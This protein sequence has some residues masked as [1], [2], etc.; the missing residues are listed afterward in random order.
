MEQ[1]RTLFMSRL[2]INPLCWVGLIL[3]LCLPSVL[4]AQVNVTVV[5]TDVTCFGLSDGTATATATGGWEPYTFEWSNGATTSAVTGLAAGTYTVKAT[6]KDLGYDIDT[7][8][9]N[10]PLQLGV[11]VAATQPQI[12]TLAPDGKAVATPFGGVIP[13]TYLWNTGATTPEIT[14]LAAG[15][16]TVTVRDANGCT[17]SAS[18][19]VELFDEGLWISVMGTPPTCFDL[20]NGSASVMTM[21]GTAPYTYVWSNG[22]STTTITNLA[23]G[24][25]TVTVSDANGCSHATS[26]E[27]LGPTKVNANA[28]AT[29]ATCGLPG[30]ASVAPTGGTGPYT[31]SWN[32]GSTNFTITVQPGTYTVT[33]TDSKGCTATATTTVGGG[34]NPLTVNVTV[35]SNAGCTTSGSATAIASGGSGNYAYVWDNGQTTATATLTAGGHSVT[36]T[37]ITTGCTGVGTVT[38]TSVTN[39]TATATSVTNASCTTGGSATATGSGGTTPYTYA[40]DNGQTTQTATNLSAGPHSVTVTD[41]TGCIAI[42]TVTI[43]QSQG[44]TVTVTANTTASCSGVG[45]SATANASGGTP[46]YV[47]LWDNTQT[48]QTATGL[49][50]GTH[51]VTV[52]DAAGCSAVG[53]V[54]IQQAGTPTAT[55]VVTAQATCTT[56]GSATATASGGAGNYGFVW[57]T[58]ATTA[59]VSNL[60]PGTYTVTVTDGAGCT[61]TASATINPPVPPVAI[62][63]ASANAKCDQPGSASASASGGVPPYTFRWDNGETTAAAVNLTP[64]AHTVT[65]TGTN[66][67]TATA[68]VNIGFAS[69]GIKIGDYVWYDRDQDGFQ[70]PAETDGVVN[71]TVMLVKAG[72]DGQFGTADDITVATTTTN[73]SGKYIFDCVTPGQYVIMFG[74]IPT[75]YEFTDIDNVNN[76]CKDS[77]ALPNGKTLP[78]TI[79]AG[80]ADN[81]CFDA[82]IH[83]KCDNV[84]N[85]GQICCNQTICEGE[86]PAALTNIAYPSGGSGVIEY[87]WLQLVQVGPSPATWVG[88]P[89]A[90]GESFAPG[91]LYETSFYM[92]CARRAGCENFLESNIVTI[93]VLPAGAPGCGGFAFNIIVEP[94]QNSMVNVKWSTHPEGDEYMYTL[95]RSTDR[96]VW[97]TVANVMGKHDAT[98]ENHYSVVDQT[99]A[100]GMNFYRI[101]R[102]NPTG[103]E[104]YSDVKQLEMLFSVLQSISIQPSLITSDELNI[105]INGE[106]PFDASVE[107]YHLNGKSVRSIQLQK[108]MTGANP[109]SVVDLAAGLYIAR[110][111]FSNGEVR[112]VKLTKV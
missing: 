102:I 77:D 82:G 5:K 106:L 95:Q 84:I 49:S 50:A 43:G 60:A 6:D 27:L 2:L 64:G 63:S 75:G 32:N 111:R 47:Y 89:G 108:G 3:A 13:Y 46:P 55:V 68:T 4:S 41:A 31:V 109:H 25:Y 101:K 24:T 88:I 26:V 54:E 96:L 103:V 59:A 20:N 35:N 57:S 1:T 40:W 93:T 18:K 78:F 19:T 90:T 70:D 45:G 48:T 112:T 22:G 58:G 80:Q 83:T 39:L 66:G 21:S 34:G 85:A 61:A 72:P 62:I 98:A 16:Y 38:I 53:S 71:L 44:P 110:I 86:M 9:I 69:N 81:L 23:A 30:S 36:A 105:R 107:I 87:Q 91:K 99:P 74:P 67:C 33:V 79:V 17:A 73:A 37:D 7:V 92:R 51:R 94:S 65:V 12:C 97:A 10:Q 100:N 52:T 42:A 14:G 28:T 15:T 29:N 56:G 8:V 11:S 76:D 104:A